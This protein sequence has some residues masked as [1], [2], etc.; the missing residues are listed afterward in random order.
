MLHCSF[1]VQGLVP[2][3]CSLTLKG[4]G[5][6]PPGLSGTINCTAGRELGSSNV[7]R[8]YLWSQVQVWE[9]RLVLTSLES[10]LTWGHPEKRATVY[11]SKRTI[12]KFFLQICRGN[13]LLYIFLLGWED[14]LSSLYTAEFTN[15]WRYTCLRDVH[16][17]NF[18]QQYVCLQSASVY[19]HQLLFNNKCLLVFY[20]VLTSKS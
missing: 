10:I 13:Y 8:Y 11:S 2:I 16:W 5:R 19:Y 7:S 6:K 15:D 4:A 9:I 17:D 12:V 18:L 20:M 1:R 3:L 14:F